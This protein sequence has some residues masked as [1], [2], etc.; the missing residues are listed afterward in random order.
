ME[1]LTSINFDQ[2]ISL[3]FSL[4]ST[5]GSY[6]CILG[7]GI[8]I[9]SGVPSAWGVQEDL[10]KQLAGAEGES[11]EDPFEW[12]ERKYG[13]QA[14][15]ESLL[16]R[17]APTQHARQQLLRGYFEPSDLERELELK[18]P[19]AAHRAI[20]RLVA[21]GSVRVILTLNFDRLMETALKDLGI[22]PVV[23]SH[24][25]DI[26]G[27]A[28]L[29]TV[30]ALIVHLHGDYLNPSAML[31]TRAELAGYPEHVDTFLDRILFDYGLILVGWSAT[32]DPALRQAISRS[33]RRVYAPY[34]IDPGQLSPVAEDLRSLIAAVKISSDADT[35]IGRLADAV[36]ALRD[37]ESR[38]P[39]V[40][41]VAVGT[42]KRYLSGRTTAV[43]LHDLLQKEFDNLH[44]QKDLLLSRTGSESPDGGYAR[45]LDRVEEATLVPTALI[46]TAAYWGTAETDQW[47]VREII[48]FT[49]ETTGPGQR[50][51]RELQLTCA[52]QMFYAAGVAATAAGRLDL[53]HALL[54]LHTEDPARRQIHLSQLLAPD[55]VFREDAAPGRRLFKLLLPLFVQHLTVGAKNFEESWDRFEF[56]RL[57]ES[58]FAKPL[59]VRLV[60]VARGTAGYLESA[61]QRMEAANSSNDLDEHDAAE[62]ELRNANR[63]HDMQIGGIA[64]EVPVFRPYVNIQ[65]T[66]IEVFRSSIG[67][68]LL[69]EIDMQGDLHPLSQAGFAG[70][71]PGD[72]T[73]LCTAVDVAIGRIGHEVAIRSMPGGSGTVPD[74][75]RIGDL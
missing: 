62:R 48:R 54:N 65:N 53:V 26:H 21:A 22:E 34:W 37:R 27:L 70:G 31:N 71:Q 38:H 12:Y 58:T 42:A 75:F 19:T 74:N 43:Q 68:R 9:P 39:L 64:D 51:V 40:P 4:H 18:R 6:A 5:P 56:L 20:A 72:L 67:Q 28:P 23:V 29:H 11:P 13:E 32:Y 3:A 59:S 7:A 73:A 47:W 1:P 49:A 24:P 14:S 61:K 52:L 25:S 41:A 15:Y 16:E 69:A 57:V 10:L 66:S 35:A 33:A 63:R 50:H 55:V 30:Q 45:M 46:A 8:S 2:V 36:D 17:L 44:R 60:E